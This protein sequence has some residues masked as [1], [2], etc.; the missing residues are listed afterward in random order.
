M[1]RRSTSCAAGR[2]IVGVEALVI[3][4]YRDDEVDRSLELT[5]VLHELAQAPAVEFALPS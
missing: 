3:E 5:V 2:R 4:T 1:R